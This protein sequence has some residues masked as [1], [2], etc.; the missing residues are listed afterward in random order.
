MVILM[1]LIMVKMHRT[2]SKVFKSVLLI[3]TNNK[4][5]MV[6]TLEKVLIIGTIIQTNI[7]YTITL[8]G[9]NTTFLKYKILVH[10]TGEE[11]RNIY[12]GESDC[13]N[14]ARVYNEKYRNSMAYV[15]S[16][17]STACRATSVGI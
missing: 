17:H 7:L 2:N 4:M 16:R 3:K 5:L 12:P 14:R 10:L 6:I 13:G 15:R 9:K 8:Q 1:L 11:A